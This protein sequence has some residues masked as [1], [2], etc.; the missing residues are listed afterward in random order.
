MI[1]LITIPIRQKFIMKK[2]IKLVLILFLLFFSFI[3]IEMI[4]FSTK[5]VN[6]STF[7]FDVNNI[8]N[9][10]I[11]KLTR[12]IDNLYAYLLLKFS[13]KHQEHLNQ[14]DKDFEKLPEFKTISSKKSNFTKSNFNEKNNLD[15]WK[16]S[17][18]NHS[19]NR[20]SNLSEVNLTNVENL[21]LVWKYKF[22]E[23]KRDIQANPV[24]AE[25]KIF[26]PTTGNKIVSIDATNGK[27][28]WEYEVDSTPARRGL[29]FSSNNNKSRIYFCAEKYLISLDAKNGQLDK[30]FGKSGTRCQMGTET[31]EGTRIGNRNS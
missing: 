8:R 15:E 29:V 21:D 4:S 16:R 30:S 27:K 31:S 24:I 6:R 11:K 28:I 26:L 9:P 12:K 14:E 7:N 20:F 3:L 5:Y 25:G 13:E 22:N 18:G 1:W 23:I 2:I 10:Q 19:S 17:H